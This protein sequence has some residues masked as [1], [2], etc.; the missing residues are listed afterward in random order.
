MSAA[1]R[2]VLRL[3]LLF[4]ICFAF[5]RASAV[6]AAEVRVSNSLSFA[7]AVAKAAAGDRIIVQSGTH[8]AIDV[9]IDK[10][11]EIIGLTGAVLD[12]QGKSQIL[13]ISASRVTIRNLAFIR[14]GMSYVSDNAAIKATGISDLKIEN[15][16]FRDN[17]FSVYLAKSSNCIVRNCS[18]K[19]SGKLESSS[20]NGIHQWYCRNSIIENNTIAG[21]RDGIY[22]EFSRNV[23]ISGNKS[24]NNIRYGL[25]FMFSDS[26]TYRNN[27][28]QENGAGV[29]VMYSRFITMTGNIFRQNWGP[30][31]YGLLLKEIADSHI[32]RNRIEGNTTGLYA[33]G[34]NRNTIHLN[35]FHR[36]GWGVKI[37]ANSSQNNF[38]DNNF[39]SNTFAVSTN[40]SSLQTNTFDANYW[41][42][43]AGYDLNRDG[44]GDAPHHPVRLFTIL[45]ERQPTS[46]ILL[47]SLFIDLLDAA[48]RA[49]PAL[50]PQTLV[51]ARPRMKPKQ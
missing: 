41:S 14:S 49:L 43:Y 39:L 28:F 12:G 32:E 40:S 13:I 47:R 1:T 30:A 45:I 36:N 8:T 19:A 11:L 18:F 23:I 29:A 17:F 33:D 5:M 24:L 44:F 16:S 35:S 48:E 7:D 22:L 26:C 38:T 46:L 51:D 3:S 10:P 25:H 6:Y 31:A 15:C 21:H 42:E 50:T 9:K 20:G 2:Q 4:S 37:Y 34:C 27:L